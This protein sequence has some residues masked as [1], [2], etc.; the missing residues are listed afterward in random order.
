M[1]HVELSRMRARRVECNSNAIKKRV[2]DA[3]HSRAQRE[4]PL[5]G[6]NT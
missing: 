6:M 3:G 5:S 4:K 1:I 2:K